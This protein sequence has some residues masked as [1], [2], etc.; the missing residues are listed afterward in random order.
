MADA[1]PQIGCRAYKRRRLP[2]LNGMFVGRSLWAARKVFTRRAHS[3]QALS[4]MEFSRIL[5]FVLRA[6]GSGLQ[7]MEESLPVTGPGTMVLTAGAVLTR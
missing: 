5:P 1:E 2:P 4:L 6:A 3:H 7:L